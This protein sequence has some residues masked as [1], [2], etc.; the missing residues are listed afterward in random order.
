MANNPIN[1]PDPTGKKVRYCVVGIHGYLG[2][3]KETWG[4]YPKGHNLGAVVNNLFWGPVPGEVLHNQDKGGWCFE[5]KDDCSDNCVI[6]AA[7]ASM[8]KPPNY[9]LFRYNCHQWAEDML[10]QCNVK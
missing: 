8:A 5:S 7:N 10:K 3:G 4:F 1:W 9:D 2:V 6:N